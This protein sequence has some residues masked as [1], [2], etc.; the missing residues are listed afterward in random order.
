MAGHIDLNLLDTVDVEQTQFGPDMKRWLSNAVDIINQQFQALD[1]MIETKGVDVG[2]AGAGPI[3]VPVIGLT[4]NDYVN[5][6]L[7][8]TSIA[9]VT[10]S[11]VSVGT[12]AFNI[13]FSSYPGP[14]AIIVYQA[15]SAQPQ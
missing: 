9:N 8:S 3:S 15:I 4:T 1:L 10:I 2:G 7:I 11:D 6:R 14:S 13:T 12:N 5:V